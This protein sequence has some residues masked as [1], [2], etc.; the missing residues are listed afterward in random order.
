M[1]GAGDENHFFGWCCWRFCFL[2][3]IAFNTADANGV[4][5]LTGTGFV[6]GLLIDLNGV[7][8]Q[9]STWKKHRSNCVIG[10]A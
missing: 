4:Y 6:N 1:V 7:V 9:T 2:S 3:A 10:I 5:T 8:S